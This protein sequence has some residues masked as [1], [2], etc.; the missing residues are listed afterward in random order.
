MPRPSG[1]APAHCCAGCLEIDRARPYAWIQRRMQRTFQFRGRLGRLCVVPRGGCMAGSQACLAPPL[2]LFW[3]RPGRPG[4]DPRRTR[5]CFPFARFGATTYKFLA[6]RLRPEGRNSAEC[7]PTRRGAWADPATDHGRRVPV[8]L[9][10]IYAHVVE[11]N[12]CCSA[13]HL[14]LHLPPTN[15]PQALD[16]WGVHVW[17]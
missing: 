9:G 14:L 2:L 11:G 13:R 6:P 15:G 7:R 8:R 17:N 4:Y 16:G 12:F 1:R 5:V 3:R 10:V